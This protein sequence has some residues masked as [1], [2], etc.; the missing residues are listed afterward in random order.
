MLL[1][2]NSLADYHRIEGR[3]KGAHGEAIHRRR[4]DDAELAHAG[5]RELQRTR[6]GG[7]GKGKYMDVAFERLELFL[8]RDAEM[9]F[10][11]DDEQPEILEGDA[12]AKQRVCADDD[13]DAS[14]CK[15]FQR[16]L[17]FFG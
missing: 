10:F 4:C 15:D 16:F 7:G 6:D 12:F 13:V 3:D 1:A 11:V 14:I 17:I 9:L 2:Q 5:E 8:L